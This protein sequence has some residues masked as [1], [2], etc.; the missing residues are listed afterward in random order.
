M[1]IFGL[2]IRKKKNLVLPN[3]PGMVEYIEE[4]TTLCN[5]QLRGIFHGRTSEYNYET[6]EY[7]IIGAV[8]KGINIGADAERFSQFKTNNENDHD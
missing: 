4:A 8:Q 5:N 2:E 6:I 1:E 3:S 7:Y